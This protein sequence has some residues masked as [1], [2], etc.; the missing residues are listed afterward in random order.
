MNKSRFLR[1]KY[2]LTG[3]L[4][5]LTNWGDYILHDIE[6]RVVDVNR[7]KIYIEQK[8]GRKES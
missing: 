1:L 6:A 8:I 5:C 4:L 2:L 7:E 3:H